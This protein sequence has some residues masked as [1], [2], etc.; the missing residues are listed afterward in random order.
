[1]NHYLQ[2]FSFQTSVLESYE[3]IGTTFLCEIL[4][5]NLLRIFLEAWKWD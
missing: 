3:N 1:M 5:D 2:G 4:P